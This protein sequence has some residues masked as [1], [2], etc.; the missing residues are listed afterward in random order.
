[1]TDSKIKDRS[2]QE[3]IWA[4]KAREP[5]VIEDLWEVLFE[6]GSYYAF[7]YNVGE[8]VGRDAAV[9]AYQRILKRGLQQ[10]RFQCTFRGYCRV[11]VVHEVQRLLDPQEKDPVE[12]NEEMI[13]EE[14][15]S[16][17][18]TPS[19]EVLK[20]LQPCLDALKDREERVIV[21][22]YF[23]EADPDKVAQILDI[24]RNYVNVIAYRA[25]RKLRDCLVSRGYKTAADLLTVIRSDLEGHIE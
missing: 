22:R 25:R 16:L 12:L 7:Y 19:L 17:R 18:R 8:D 5:Q 1:M 13:G 11:I 9:E 6:Y 24:T 2:D 20:R 14:A 3:W 4:L 15:P 21:L 23:Q 10:Y